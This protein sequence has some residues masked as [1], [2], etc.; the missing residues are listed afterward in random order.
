MRSCEPLFS[1]LF[2]SPSKFDEKVKQRLSILSF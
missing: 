1:T 2:I